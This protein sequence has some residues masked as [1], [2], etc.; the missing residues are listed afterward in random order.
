MGWGE[1]T[2]PKAATSAR[3]TARADH[4]RCAKALADAVARHLVAPTTGNADLMHEALKA[5]TEARCAW[6]AM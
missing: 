4:D 3:M 5:F 6:V 2:R 1:P